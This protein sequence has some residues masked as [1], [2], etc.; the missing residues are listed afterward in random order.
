MVPGTPEALTTGEPD[1]GGPPSTGRSGGRDGPPAAAGRAVVRCCTCKAGDEGT[2]EG[3]R[4]GVC[5]E[6]GSGSAL[7]AGLAAVEN[8]TITGVEAGDLPADGTTGDLLASGA[9]RPPGPISADATLEGG[10]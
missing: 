6:V 9:T 2:R 8:S 4:C 10:G 5:G 7:A 3:L 1:A